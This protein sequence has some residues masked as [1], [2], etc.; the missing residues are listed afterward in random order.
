MWV[1]KFP[2]SQLLLM[3]P[4]DISSWM[5][6]SIRSGAPSSSQCECCGLLTLVFHHSVSNLTP[7]ISNGEGPTLSFKKLQSSRLI[8][9]RFQVRRNFDRSPTNRTVE[10]AALRWYGSSN[11]QSLYA[12]YG[13][14]AHAFRFIR[15]LQW[16][17]LHDNSSFH[18]VISQFEVFGSLYETK[19]DAIS[20]P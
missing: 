16:G 4:S 1:R 8:A 20:L 13:D 19:I 14:I 15:L 11:I 6:L 2:S 17:T 3:V 5:V 10:G 18:F 9:Y 7:I 12:C